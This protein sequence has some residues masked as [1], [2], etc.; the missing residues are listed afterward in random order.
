MLNGTVTTAV[1]AAGYKIGFSDWS[2]STDIARKL[3]TAIKQ[4]NDKY[5][6]DLEL[7]VPGDTATEGLD[8]ASGTLILGRRA[9]TTSSLDPAPSSFNRKTLRSTLD[10]VP[11]VP[12]EYWTSLSKKVED[13]EGVNEEQPGLFLLSWGPLCYGATYIGTAC[14]N[15]DQDDSV[16]TFIAN[17]DMNQRWTDRGV[18]G[19]FLDSASFTDIR[20]LDFSEDAH[21]EHLAKTD[22][23]DDPGYFL[24][25][26]YD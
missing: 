16:Y 3:A 8:Q 23:L 26:R 15:A 17:Q 13:F 20:A 22:K 18:D 9:V 2:V 1:I 10:S 24:V 12:E 11:K 5:E 6:L 21:A 4:Q 14:H 7:F 19:V 25:C